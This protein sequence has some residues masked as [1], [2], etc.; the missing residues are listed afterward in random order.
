MEKRDA[1]ELLSR[2][3]LLYADMINILNDDK[4]EPPQ[5]LAANQDGVLLRCGHLIDMAAFSESGCERLL[6]LF[7]RAPFLLCFHGDFC[8]AAII[9][10]FGVYTHANRCRQAVYTKSQ[11]LPEQEYDFEIRPM[12]PEHIETAA[13]HYGLGDAEYLADRME[14]G[15]LFGAF[16][17]NKL[18]GFIGVHSEGSMGM[19]EVLPDYRR[20]G[21]GSALERFLTN[22]RLDEGMIPFGQV[23]VGNEASFALQRSLGFEFADDVVTW[24]SRRPED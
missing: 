10:R 19:L 11:K 7:D 5:I 6:D 3:R 4:E 20:R 13:A 12:E 18:A 2:N 21:I 15:K 1:I 22:R 9:R 23:I 14:R 8:E 17:G 24:L 16:Y